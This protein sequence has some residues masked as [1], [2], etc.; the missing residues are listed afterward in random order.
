MPE[1]NDDE[2]RDEFIERCMADDEANRDFP[3]DDQRFAFCQAQWERNQDE[4]Q[5]MNL[6]L[7][8]VWAMYPPAREQMAAWLKSG[9]ANAVQQTPEAAR[10]GDRPLFQMLDGGVAKIPIRGVITKELDIFAMLFGGTSTVGARMALDQAMADDKVNAIIMPVDSPGG[11]VDGL[12]E[13]GDAIYA[14]QQ[15]KQI[16]VQSDGMIASAAY[17]LSSQA[18]AIYA[19]RMDLIG[20]LGVRLTLFDMSVMFAEAGI[21]TVVVDTAPE[22]RPFKSAGEIGT[23]ITEDQRADFQR[24]VDVYGDDFRRMIARGRPMANDQI[25]AVFDGRVWPAGEAMSQ[26]LIDG[27]QSFQETLAQLIAENSR[28]NFAARRRMAAA[29]L[30]SKRQHI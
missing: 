18:S 23:E 2:T 7:C 9:W 27:I 12:A 29:R 10:R 8:T 11:S 26:G 5:S 17:Y 14:A 20:S 3:D 4:S 25:D 6:P 22:D 19:N 16:V 13:L 24:I 30:R 21:E 1:P 15:K 28:P